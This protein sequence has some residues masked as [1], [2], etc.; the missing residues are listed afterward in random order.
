MKSRKTLEDTNIFFGILPRKLEKYTLSV[1]FTSKYPGLQLLKKKTQ[2]K[3]F[4]FF[5]QENLLPLIFV[6]KLKNAIT[7]YLI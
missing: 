3:P 5:F 1:Q 7:S 4:F 2:Y 6:N